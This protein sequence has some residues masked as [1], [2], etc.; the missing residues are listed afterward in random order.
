MGVKAAH[1]TITGLE[2]LSLTPVISYR[3]QGKSTHHKLGIAQ[4][5]QRYKINLMAE[6]LRCY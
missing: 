2:V 5:Q 4:D 1:N 6:S 3:V